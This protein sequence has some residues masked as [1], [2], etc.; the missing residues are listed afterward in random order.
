MFDVGNVGQY[1]LLLDYASIEYTFS[2]KFSL[3]GG[4]IRR[5]AGIYNHIQDVDLART[6]VLLPQGLYDARWR[7]FSGSLDGG[8]VFGNFSL[9]KAGNLSYESYIGM[10]SMADNGGVARTLQNSLPAPA[11]FGQYR[12]ID[13]SLI[14]GSQFWWSTPVDGL[15]VGASLGYL[16]DFG[17][18]IYVDPFVGGPGQ[19][20]E[21]GNIPFQQY[22][23][24]Y[25]WKSW[26]FQGEY[27]TYNFTGHDYIG[28]FNAKNVQ[29]EPGSWYIGA[30]RRINKWF[31]VGAYYTE[32]YTDKNDRNGASSADHQRDT[33]LSLR[34]D[35][36]DW[37][38]IK[39]EGHYIN[40]T[41][42]LNDNANNPVRDDRGW[43]MLAV[44]STFTF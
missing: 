43:F 18:T 6:Y 32:H 7:D 19:I 11:P 39:L 23:V 38:I 36:K 1:D 37:W 22:S 14:V 20:H 17:Y 4:R 24:E 8:E 28:G 35:P 42:L 33:A 26:T 12:G 34:F 10:V 13:Q 27:Y 40:G 16:K 3:R 29:S 31:E 21:K 41:A 2:D 15:R 44:K 5:P 30:S 9:G 25:V